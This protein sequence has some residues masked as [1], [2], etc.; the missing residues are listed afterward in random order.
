MEF[1]IVG[2]FLAYIYFTQKDK[3][4]LGFTVHVTERT[5]EAETLDFA[6]HL[7]EDESFEKWR[8]KLNVA[9]KFAEDRRKFNNDR[10][11]ALYAEAEK[12][13]KENTVTPFKK[14]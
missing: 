13:K 6:T 3:R 7:Y 1:V 9:Y 2:C 14:G 4:K 5:E 12:A 11:M 8:E 10:M